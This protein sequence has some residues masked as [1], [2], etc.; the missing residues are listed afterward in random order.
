MI[1]GTV[2]KSKLDAI[3]LG[4][5]LCKALKALAEYVSGPYIRDSTRWVIDY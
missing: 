1:G 3:I 4:K 2:T 5:L